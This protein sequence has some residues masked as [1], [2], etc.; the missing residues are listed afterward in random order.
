MSEAKFK[1]FA[2]RALHTG[3]FIFEGSCIVY[4]LYAS[5][6]LRHIPTWPQGRLLFLAVTVIIVEGLVLA[7][8]KGKCPLTG[9][10]QKYGGKEQR[11]ADLFLPKVFSPYAL[12]VLTAMFIFAIIVLIIKSTTTL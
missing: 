1:L 4:V 6:T 12:R 5:L 9:L 7:L 3:I 10:A 11:V 8:N 2:I